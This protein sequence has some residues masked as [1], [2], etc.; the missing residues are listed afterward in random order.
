MKK[1]SNSLTFF[2]AI[3]FVTIIAALVVCLIFFTKNTEDDNFLDAFG[4]NDYEYTS[5][6]A[7]E[8]VNRIF[9]NDQWYVENTNITTWVFFGLDKYKEELEDE[10]DSSSTQA[11]FIMLVVFDEENQTYSTIQINRDTM[12]DIDVLSLDGTSITGSVFAQITLAHAYGT[13]LVQSAENLVRAVSS[14]I[15]DTQIDYYISFPLDIVSVVNDL[16]GGVELEILY[17]YSAQY[18]EM[19]VGET[20]TLTGEQALSYVQQ[21]YGIEDQTNEQRMQRQIQ[22]LEALQQTIAAKQYDS[23][24]TLDLLL[25]V[26]DYIYT[27]ASFT[28][29]QNAM[30]MYSSFEH[31]ANYTIE[32]ETVLGDEFMEFYADDT[33]LMEL[34][35]ELFYI[36]E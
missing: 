27:Q 1:K 13:T 34:I 29:L 14:F 33:Q 18:P 22:Y 2:K 20:V 4:D 6:I 35:L 32:G 30:D 21:R 36:A 15:Y 24:F 3:S 23:R 16:V 5:Y 7:T 19:I 11:D 28:L 9:Q 17:D 12:V 26:S 31:V 8:E 25:G 10:D